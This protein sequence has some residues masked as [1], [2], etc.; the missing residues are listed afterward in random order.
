[1]KT[2]TK[3][4]FVDNPEGVRRVE[5]LAR[6]DG[7]DFLNMKRKPGQWRWGG[8][9]LRF[10]YEDPDEKKWKCLVHKIPY[11]VHG[12][13]GG[14]CLDF[15][16]KLMGN[17]FVYPNPTDK[18]FLRAI[19]KVKKMVFRIKVEIS[20]RGWHTLIDIKDGPF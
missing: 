2:N 7:F 20:P 11:S 6:F 5:R 14:V 13:S 1:M 3:E 9:A 15:L 12:D 18:S 4:E 19:L 17:N 8:L 16:V 10:S